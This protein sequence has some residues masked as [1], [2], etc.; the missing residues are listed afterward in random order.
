MFSFGRKK[1]S[2][3]REMRAGAARRPKLDRRNAGKNINYEPPW[4]ST[5]SDES[6]SLRTTRSLDISPEAYS[7]QTSFRI[8][9]SIEGEVEILYR[10]LGISGPEDFA[11][12]ADAWEATLKARSSSDLLPRSRFFNSPDRLQLQTENPAPPSDLPAEAGAEAAVLSE[13]IGFRDDDRVEGSLLSF[14]R[15]GGGDGGIKGARPP[16][17]TPPPLSPTVLSPPPV[18]LVLARPPSMTLPVDDRP[19]STWDIVRSFAPVDVNV[20]GDRRRS[21]DSD[22]DE[23]LVEG[24]VGGGDAEDNLE[25]EVPFL[26]ETSD[27]TGSFS[28]S[29]DDDSSSTTTESM[30]V[31]SPNGRFKKKITS[32]MRGNLLGSGSFGTVYEGIS[33]DGTFIAVKEVSLIDKGSNAEQCIIQLEQEIALL[34]Q[35]EHENIVQY[36]GTDKEEAKLFIFLELVTQGSL[37]S[38]YQKY[39]L[40]DSQVSAYTRQI[41]NGLNYLH[42]RNVVHRDIKCANI[43]VHANGSVKLADFGLAKE[44]SKFNVLKSCKGSVYW[45]APEVVHPR[46]TYGRAAD[47]WS[48]GCTVLEMLTR[49]IP[50]PNV[51]WQ[52]A[53][54]KIGCGDQPPIPSHLSKDAQDFIRQCVQVDPSFRPSAAQLFEHPFVKRPLSISSH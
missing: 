54:Y 29:N 34:S 37:A 49:Q 4:V 46:K 39:H 40:R 41:L 18:R 11:I 22:E 25:E 32:W 42:E 38:L 7:K 19:T 51:E 50:F 31:I 23:V 28:T 24:R 14:V 13:E 35:F 2:H 9:G 5:S 33:D 3:R 20:E 52:H 53:F 26:G 21:V 27:C 45:M 36:Y 12:P 15:S 17:L 43:L 8:G 1:A 6:P 48:L 10:S 16:A 47:I 30:F 44:I